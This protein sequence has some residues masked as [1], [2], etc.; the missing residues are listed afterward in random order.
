MAKT[1][2]E[3]EE[4]E[5]KKKKKKRTVPEEAEEPEQVNHEE[6]NAPKKKKKKKSK[7]TEDAPAVEDAASPKKRKVVEE[8]AEDA[9]KPILKFSYANFPA[10]LFTALNAFPAPTPIQAVAWGP[11]F[12]G[13][14]IVGIAATGSGLREDSVRKTRALILSPTRELAS[15]I[16]ESLEKF[17]LILGIRIVVLFG[18]TNKMEQRKLLRQGADVVVATPGRLMD[19]VSEGCCDLSDVGY[20]VLDEADRMLDK[21]FEPEI[22]KIAAELK[23]SDLQTVMFSATWPPE[24][25]KLSDQYLK[26]PVHITIGSQDLSANISITQI[27]EVIEPMKKRTRLLALL[28]DYHKS[29]KNKIIIFGLYKKGNVAGRGIDIPDVEYV[30]NY[31]YPLTTEDYCHRIGRTGRAGKKGVAHTFFTSFDKA[32]SGSLINVLKQAGQVVP[33]DLMKFGTTVKKKL[34]PTYGAFTREID[35]NAKSVKTKFDDEDSD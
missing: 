3:E 2:L 20:F 21:G 23:R 33:A 5:K 12:K 29:R 10:D 24:V 14:D 32:H 7:E 22:K 17:G 9:S 15:Q 13:R 11:A 8:D 34:D 31:T 35:P 6:D 30:I 26:N 1:K 28:S 25:R 4:V 19:L 27:V 18:G 16:Q